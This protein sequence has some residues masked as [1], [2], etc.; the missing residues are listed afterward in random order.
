MTKARLTVLAVDDDPVVLEALHVVLSRKYNVLM[1]R[2]GHEAIELAMAHDVDLVLLDIMMPGFDGLST[3]LLMREDEKTRDIPIIMLTAVG[4]KEK[5][6]E[7]F[8]DG[9]SGYMLKPFR[10]DSLLHK[11]ET[12]LKASADKKKEE[13]EKRKELE[14]LEKETTPEDSDSE[15]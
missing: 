2:D 3:L 9:A 1:C 4:K 8:R 15:S 14:E 7:A 6:V 13:E 12:V 5:V 10:P 11:I